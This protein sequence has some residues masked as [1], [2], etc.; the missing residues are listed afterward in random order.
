MCLLQV[1]TYSLHPVHAQTEPI[2]SVCILQS[3]LPA[4]A[5]SFSHLFLDTLLQPCLLLQVMGPVP[6]TIKTCSTSSAALSSASAFTATPACS[7]SQSP[8]PISS[9]ATRGH[10]SSLS[11]STSAPSTATP[12][13]PLP[14][15]L[16]LVM[17]SSAS[18]PVFQPGQLIALAAEVPHLTPKGTNWAIFARHIERA[19]RHTH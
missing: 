7:Q 10:S 3:F 19:I 11:L 8:T 14:A 9:T 5:H 15:P 18:T 2:I 17:S 1:N 13:P 6:W 16:S 12:P 4:L